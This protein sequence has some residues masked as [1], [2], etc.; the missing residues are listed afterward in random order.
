MA[1]WPATAL[2]II[3]LDSHHPAEKPLFTYVPFT[4]IQETAILDN[5]LE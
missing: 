3:T 1:F 2:N 4:K 5:P